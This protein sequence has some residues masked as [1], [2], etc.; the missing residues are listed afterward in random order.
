VEKK[1]PHVAT[2][3]SGLGLLTV[4]VSCPLSRTTF[5]CDQPDAE[6][7]A[8]QHTTLTTDRYPFLRRDSNP[9]SQQASGRR[10]TARPHGS[11]GRMPIE[12]DT[13]LLVG[14]E[15][16]S[17]GCYRISAL[18]VGYK[19]EIQFE[20]HTLKHFEEKINQGNRRLVFAN[21]KYI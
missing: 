11:V 20:R 5:R 15:M 12:I 6:T 21:P 3:P 10:P 7:S 8:S 2:V 19:L 13:N 14:A 17:Y 9:N 4:E 16:R 1:S 18:S